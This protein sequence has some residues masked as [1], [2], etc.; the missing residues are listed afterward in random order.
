MKKNL[1]VL[2][3]LSILFYS[4]GSTAQTVP[5]ILVNL[6]R[7]KLNWTW[8]PDAA[9]SPADGFRVKCGQVTG[10]YTKITELP[11]P[12]ARTAAIK[13]VIAGNGNW[14]CVVAVFNGFGEVASS[15]LPFVAGASPSGSIVVTISVN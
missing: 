4:V 10:V 6:N 14:F 1:V 2:L 11:T 7:A 3:V 13:D 9:S 12:T 8:T 5:T 15:E